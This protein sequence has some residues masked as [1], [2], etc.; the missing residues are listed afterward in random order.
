MSQL[1][2]LNRLIDG[3][4]GLFFGYSGFDF[5]T[6]KVRYFSF[7]KNGVKQ[8]QLFEFSLEN[9]G[10]IFN[11][12]L[13]FKR[14]QRESFSKDLPPEFRLMK[15]KLLA[16]LKTF[17]DN[18]SLPTTLLEKN[19]KFLSL[20][21]DSWFANFHS[22][23]KDTILNSGC[24]HELT[25]TIELYCN[26]AVWKGLTL[27]EK[28]CLYCTLLHELC[29]MEASTSFIKQNI[30]FARCGF[31]SYEIPLKLIQEINGD[32]LYENDNP[33]EL[34][35]RENILEEI[36]N[37]YKCT[38]ITQNYIKSY[39][40][41][42][43]VINDLCDNNLLEARY[44]NGIETYYERMTSIIPSTFLAEELLDSIDE[45]NLEETNQLILEYKQK[46]ANKNL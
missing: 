22:E 7:Y 8:Q 45:E 10:I 44:T 23:F 9:T 15:E 41:Y 39:P 3:Y 37:E 30:L 25:N 42:G 28:Y 11:Y 17:N 18:Y 43:S 12:R 16:K 20:Q 5:D 27:S 32:L 6:H 35:K 29:H 26:Q 31:S 40:D 19:K 38:L 21:Y 2:T 24:Y 4:S 36:I 46:K 13:S 14:I 1:F 33:P 34:N